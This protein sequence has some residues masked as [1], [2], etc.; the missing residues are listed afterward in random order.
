[1]RAPD[2]DTARGNP[3]VLLALVV[4]AVVLTTVYFREG[5]GGPLHQTRAGVLAVTAPLE[6]AGSFATWPF[7]A[8]GDFAGGLTVSR[9][10]VDKLRTQNDQLR[11]RITSLQDQEAENARLTALLQ[12][13]QTLRLPGF[14]ARVIGLPT[15]SW[16]G[17]LVVDRGSLAGVKTGMAVTAAQGLVGQVVEVAPNASKIRLITDRRSGVAVFVQRN[18]APGIVMGSLDGALSLDFVDRR[19]NTRQGDVVVTSGMGG[20][21]PKGIVVGDVTSVH[22]ERDKPFPMLTVTSRVPITAVEEVFIVTQPP[23]KLLEPK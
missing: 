7:R 5:S 22:D 3:I 14:A 8:V 10:D 11:S 13:K 1:M 21:Y 20:V 23:A 12:L 15:N 19:S 9:S 2:I 16:E 6:Q 4:I 18:R 17:A